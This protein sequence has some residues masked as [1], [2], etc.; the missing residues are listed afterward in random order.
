MQQTTAVIV[1]A[2]APVAGRTKTRLIPELGPERAAELYRCFLLD[3]LDSLRHLP[4][5]L[6][7]AAAE[8][9]DAAL[10][11]AVLEGPDRA[12]RITVQAGPDLGERILSAVG[13]TLSQGYRAALVIGT[14]SP[15][16]PAG[17]IAGALDLVASHDLVLGP[18]SDG[19]YYL[20]GLRGAMPRLFEDVEWS[21]DRVLSGTLER[22]EELGLATALLETW[23]DVDTADD[24]RRLRERLA[25]QDAA[26][27]PIVC[28]RT[29]QYLR[30]LPD[31]L[32]ATPPPSRARVIIVIP[33]LNE[34]QSIGRVIQAIPEELAAQ[35]VVVDNGSTDATAQI[36][37]AHGARVVAEPRRGYGA[38]CLAG[39]AA[40]GQPEV[41]AFLDAD[42]SDDPG[43]LRELVELI[44]A[45]RADLVI[46]SRMLGERERGALPLHSLLGNW[47]AGLILT[48]LYRQPTT[49]LGPFRAIR[50]SALDRLQMQDRGFG[51]TME[52]QAKAAR[53]KLRVMEI[54]VPYRKRIGRSKITGSLKASVRAAAIILWTA[55]RLL[56]W[57]PVPTMSPPLGKS[58]DA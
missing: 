7:V 9:G 21:S 47:L 38:A 11:R 45:G 14:D 40:A 53:L 50:R 10:L 26:G 4:A 43:K 2:R 24:L 23:E 37:R 6:I 16:L 29:W 8:P 22:A 49:D 52:M 33:A 18:C 36:A 51:W 32:A 12:G 15:D 20:I 44:L 25:R 19:G 54:P 1:F 57:R 41:I 31:Q 35:V 3:T 17:V 13:Q 58:P 48:H 42:F 28:P 34:E 56:R 39:I 46:G 30:D 27:D 5:D 55:F